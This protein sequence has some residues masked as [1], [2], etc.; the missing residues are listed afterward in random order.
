MNT[1]AYFHLL[2]SPTPLHNFPCF[3]TVSNH[4]SPFPPNL[5]KSKKP[6]SGKLQKI[7]WDKIFGIPTKFGISESRSLI[8]KRAHTCCCPNAAANCADFI[9][10]HS[11]MFG[12]E[13][14]SNRGGESLIW[15]GRKGL[16]MRRGALGKLIAD[17]LSCKFREIFKAFRWGG[18]FQACSGDGLI[19][20]GGFDGF[21]QV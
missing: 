19:L 3:L 2:L 18:A 13:K 17:R 14:P 21:V 20:G 12:S 1:S 5:F 7:G 6:G 9:T 4:K 8:R 11:A 10:L 15:G 16:V